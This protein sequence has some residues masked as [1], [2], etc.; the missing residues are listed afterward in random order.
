LYFF[1]VI[2]RYYSKKNEEICF[3][4]RSTVKH[5]YVCFTITCRGLVT[6]LLTSKLNDSILSRRITTE[7]ERERNQF[8]K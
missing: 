8:Y 3:F 5:F 1:D 2:A 4:D 6:F 7:R